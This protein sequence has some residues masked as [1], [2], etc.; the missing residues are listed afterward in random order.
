MK[1]SR[2]PKRILILYQRFP[3]FKNRSNSQKSAKDLKQPQRIIQ[4]NM[5]ELVVVLLK[6]A[7][8]T[9]TVS[10]QIMMSLSGSEYDTISKRETS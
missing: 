2:N 1:I 10:R 3:K 5:K 7:H 4:K 6:L 8:L 9:S